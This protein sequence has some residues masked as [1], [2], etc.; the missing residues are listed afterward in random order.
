MLRGQ[1]LGQ[2]HRLSNVSAVLF[3]R[4]GSIVKSNMSCVSSRMNCQLLCLVLGCGW[5]GWVALPFTLAA[6]EASK[7]RVPWI[8]TRLVGTPEAPSPFCAVPAYPQLKPKHP[9]AAMREPGAN[10]IVYLENY[11]YDELRGVLRR[12]EA[13]SDVTEAEVLLELKEHV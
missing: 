4:F 11:G 3:G 6:A 7:P 13:K 9:I 12:F 1:S 5:F 2:A 10:R 8:N